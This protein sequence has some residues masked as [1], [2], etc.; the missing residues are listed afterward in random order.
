M[1]L[2]DPDDIG[3]NLLSPL[4][5]ATRI[6]VPTGFRG[7]L[8]GPSGPKSRGPSSHHVWH[9]SPRG[10]LSRCCHAKEFSRVLSIS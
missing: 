8:W 9:F 4:G 1:K 6:V 10:T 7:R 2:P 3:M 5:Y